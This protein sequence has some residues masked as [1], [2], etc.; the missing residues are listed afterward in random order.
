MFSLLQ[1][2]WLEVHL[3]ED[4]VIVIDAHVRNNKALRINDSSLTIKKF[5]SF[6]IFQQVSIIFHFNL[7]IVIFITSIDT[8]IMILYI[9]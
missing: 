8:R 3:I 9:L 4:G 7:S 1:I 5:N 6:K 2:S